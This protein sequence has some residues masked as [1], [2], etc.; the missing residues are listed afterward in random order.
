MGA[1][2]LVINGKFCLSVR[3][4][5]L[6]LHRHLLYIDVIPCGNEDDPRIENMP[7]IGPIS[8]PKEDHSN[9]RGRE[10]GGGGGALKFRCWLGSFNRE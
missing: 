5:T 7:F 9:V 4:A 10:R 2:I 8:P 1:F 3:W 6:T